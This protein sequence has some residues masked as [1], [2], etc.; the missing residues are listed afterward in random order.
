MNG[1]LG[2]LFIL[3]FGGIFI[4]IGLARIIF[5][6]L[7][8]GSRVMHHAN[9]NTQETYRNQTRHHARDTTT[10]GN[11]HHERGRAN[12]RWRRSG[13]IFDKNEG[14]YVDFEEL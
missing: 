9:R 13:K 5:R 7:F 3:I 2:C 6:L 12:S 11:A 1:L 14:Q 10:S 8:G 4:F